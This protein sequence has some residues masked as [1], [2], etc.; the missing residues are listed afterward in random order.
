MAPLTISATERLINTRR[1]LQRY[2]WSDGSAP[3]HG[4]D[5]VEIGWN[6]V[7]ITGAARVD[8]WTFSLPHGETSYVY[9]VV[10]SSPK[11]PR[12]PIIVHQGHD[13]MLNLT[14]GDSVAYFA[15]QGFDVLAM[16]MPCWSPNPTGV[17]VAT[18]AGTRTIDEHDDLFDLDLDGERVRPLRIYLDPVVRAAEYI[19]VELG[20]GQVP[21][22]GLSGGGWTTHIA[23]AVIERINPTYAVAGFM[24]HDLGEPADYEQHSSRPIY[25]IAP[26]RTLFALA[27]L[28]KRHWQILNNLDYAFRY[29]GR[30]STVDAYVADVKALLETN[31]LGFFDLRVDTT[32][33]EQEHVMSANTRAFIA[34]DLATH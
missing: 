24:P 26:V 4:P 33:A 5:V 11:S 27:G 29:E 13:P 32:G 3:T 7:S 17:Q 21:M 30:E 10:P 25:T 31:T 19:A 9:R 23:A 16:A 34:T 18:R 8:R 2:I 1:M 15:Q 12:R 22:C 6:G 28:G 20:V 14:V